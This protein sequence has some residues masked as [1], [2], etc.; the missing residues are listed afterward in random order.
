[1]TR[2]GMTPKCLTRFSLIALLCVNAGYAPSLSRAEASVEHHSHEW[3]R[4]DEADDTLEIRQ[5][6]GRTLEWRSPQF[7]QEEKDA[8]LHIQLLGINDFHG[9][10][11]EGRRVANRPVGGAAVLAAYLHA[12]Q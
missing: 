3:D 8:L 12:A 4:D 6:A 10:L 9:Q 1:M 11:S 5:D 2:D 7:R